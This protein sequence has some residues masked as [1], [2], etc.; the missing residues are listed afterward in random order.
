MT[1]QPAVKRAFLYLIILQGIHSIEE[2]VGKIWQLF[3][4]AR[5]LCSL[6]SEDLEHGFLVINIGLFLFGFFCYFIP[7]RGDYGI[8]TVIVWFW[9]CL[10]VIN[11][12][13]HIIW[14]VI[15]VGYTPGFFTAPILLYV[16]I[17]LQQLQR[18]DF[19]KI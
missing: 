19:E 14:S 11:G 10:E 1:M 4:P 7:V 8:G 3:A 17:R 15:E 13:G 16:A 2:Y 12:T 9:I 6:I 5:F 18:H